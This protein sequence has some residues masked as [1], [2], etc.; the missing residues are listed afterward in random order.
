MEAVARRSASEE[1]GV[2]HMVTV[3]QLDR[4]HVVPSAKFMV[5]RCH[6]TTNMRET[7]RRQSMTLQKNGYEEGCVE[8]LVH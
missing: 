1:W 3:C 4:L 8:M 5:S 2:K 7:L 6:T